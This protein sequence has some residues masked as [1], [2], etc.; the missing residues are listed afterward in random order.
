MDDPHTTTLTFSCP[1]PSNLTTATR[2]RDDIT[3][4]RIGRDPRSE[5]S[6]LILSPIVLA[7][8]AES[9]RL[10]YGEHAI[11]YVKDGWHASGPSAGRPTELSGW[12][13]CPCRGQT[14]ATMLHG[15]LVRI[16]RRLAH[17]RCPL[18]SM[19]ATPPSTQSIVSL[20]ATRHSGSQMTG[21]GNDGRRTSRVSPRDLSE[22]PRVRRSRHREQRCRHS[23][24][25]SRHQS[26]RRLDLA[27][28]EFETSTFEFSGRLRRSAGMKVRFH[29]PVFL[30]PSI[31]ASSTIDSMSLGS[32][33]EGSSAENDE[34]RSM[35]QCWK[36]SFSSSHFVLSPN[37]RR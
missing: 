23:D 35:F 5:S 37:A 34:L 8:L 33:A 2:T 31:F 14:R 28:S 24:R 18:L 22:T 13:R 7:Q 30:P 36:T 10:N 15:P 16:V 19:P 29:W 26:M 12:P 3:R 27:R 21:D 9:W 32:N 17:L 20:V 1:R 6:T 25:L 11:L 4:L